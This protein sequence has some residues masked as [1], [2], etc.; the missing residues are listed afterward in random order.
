LPSSANERQNNFNLLRLI[1]ALLVLL[2]HA[3]ELADGNRNREILT[4]VFHTM[5][6]GEAAVAGFFLLSGYLIVQSWMSCPEVLEFLKKRVLRIYPAFIVATAISAFVVGP[7]AAD[8]A[9]YFS[10]FMPGEFTKALIL[11]EIPKI[12]NVFSGTPYAI[13]NGSMWTIAYEFTC[14]LMVILL[15]LSGAVKK[16]GLWAA[17][18]GGILSTIILQKLGILA[19]WDDPFLRLA[20]YFFCG[21]CFYLYK[22][23]IPLNKKM[24]AAMSIALLVGMFSYR[25]AELAFA[26]A[27]AYLLFYIALSPI[28]GLKG[29]NRYPDVSYGA[30][31]YGWPV[32]KLLLWYFPG[33]SP[34]LLFAL[35]AVACITLGAASWSLVEKPALSLKSANLGKVVRRGLFN[36]Q[37]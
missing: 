5:S 20:S 30:Y 37:Q 25:G 26:T 15:G 35:S 21:G 10:S 17:A 27:G 12:P 32:Q 31:L 6:F 9:Q 13:V 3:P 8:P 29:F 2:S 33:M 34:W 7:L 28:Q 23:K 14:Y 24:A 36:Q 18:T 4:R 22:E 11:L 16:R 1:F 19:V